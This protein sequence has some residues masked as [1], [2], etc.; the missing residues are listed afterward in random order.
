M[1]EIYIFSQHDELLTAL[2]EETGLISAVFREELNQLP[3]QPFTFTMDAESEKAAHVLEENQVV[4]RDK[5]GELRLY[6]IKEI[7]DADGL[8]GPETIAICEPA[9]MELSEKTVVE[10][11]FIETNAQRALTAALEGTRWTG[12]VETDLSVATT[13]FFYLSA[14]D[15]IWR[16]LEVWGGEFKDVVEFNGNRITAREIRILARRGID[17]G[18]RFDIEH[19]V[20]EIQR[21]VMSYP[22]TAIYGRGASLPIEDDEGDHTGGY[23]S[24][25]DFADVEWRKSAGDPVDKPKG[26]R[27]V[28]D[29]QALQKYGRRHGDKLLHR[30]GIWQN[31]NYDEPEEVLKATWEQLLKV[32]K[33]EI[34]Y[35][36]SVHLLESLAGY[37]HEKVSLGDTARAIDR[38]FAR[39][40]EIQARVIAI[41]Y[42]LLDIDTTAVVEIGQ[43]LSAH[44]YDD[45]LDNVVRE[46]NDNRG[47]WEQ[48]AKP[49]DRNSYPDIVPEVPAGIEATGGFQII[50]VFWD[51]NFMEY[52]IQHYELFASQVKG[53]LPSPETMVYRGP[54]NGYNLKGETNTTY[55]FRARA[56]NYHDRAS[57]YTAE[58]SASTVRVMTDDL[59]FG[60]ELAERLREL[61]KEADIIGKDG[62]NFDQI[63]QDA[64]DRIHNRAKVYSDQE[65]AHAYNELSEELKS[66][67]DDVDANRKEL[68]EKEKQLKEDIG[69][70]GEGLTDIEE[71]FTEQFEMIDGR[72]NGL[73]SKGEVENLL[74]DKVDQT[75]YDKRM[76]EIGASVEG[77]EF[78]LKQTSGT[79]D[80]L[81]GDVVNLREITADLKFTADGFSTS[82]QEIEKSLDEKVDSEVYRERQASLD[83]TLEGITGSVSDI[84]SDLTSITDRQAEFS[85]TL[86]GFSTSVT[87]LVT[88][89]RGSGSG[90][91]MLDTSSGEKEQ[92]R[93][94]NIH[95][96]NRISANERE[97]WVE[98]T[99]SDASTT[100]RYA[101]MGATATN[102]LQGLELNQYYTFS[103][104][105][106]IPSAFTGTLPAFRSFSYR[107][108]GWGS[109]NFPIPND[110][111]RDKWV[112][113]SFTFKLHQNATGSMLRIEMRG[114]ANQTF[115]ARKF[116][117]EKGTVAS[118]WSP[119]SVDYV[120]RQTSLDATLEGISGRV[121]TTEDNLGSITSR[122]GTLELTDST[123][124]TRITEISNDL[125]GKISREGYSTSS[126]SSNFGGQWTRFARVELRAQYHQKYATFEFNGGNHSG[127]VG[128]YG[129]LFL[130]VKQQMAIGSGNP[131]VEMALRDSKRNIG[132]NDFKAVL[133]QNASGR[134]IVDFYLRIRDNHNGFAISSYNEGGS[135]SPSML[136]VFSNQGF[137]TSVPSGV[138]WDASIDNTSL[139]RISKAE[140]AIEQT[141]EA[142]T[143]LA[144]QKEVDNLSGR[145]STSEGRIDVMSNQIGLRVEKDGIISAINIT[146]EQVKIDTRLLQI[147]NFSNLIRDSEME[148]IKLHFIHAGNWSMADA[149]STAMNNGRVL[150]LGTTQNEESR[151]YLGGQKMLRVKE[152]EQY[153]FSIYARPSNSSPWNSIRLRFRY[154]NRAGAHVGWSHSETHKPPGFV[155]TK[156]VHNATV[157]KDAYYLEATLTVL[158]EGSSF[159]HHFQDPSLVRRADTEMIVDGSITAN[160]MTANSITAGNAAIANAA[161]TRANLQQAIISNAYIADG[162][163]QNAKIANG[164]I[165]NAKI[166]NATITDGKIVSLTANKITA[167][168]IDAS[169]VNIIASG[170]GVIRMNRE[171]F[172]AFDS[173][174]RR[175]ILINVQNVGGI[176]SDP[177]V[178]RFFDPSGSNMGYIGANNNDTFSIYSTGHTFIDSTRPIEFRSNEFRFNP[179]RNQSSGRYWVMGWANASGKSGPG[180]SLRPDTS[181]WGSIGT[182]THRIWESWINHLHT[183]EQHQISTREVKANIEE[184]NVEHFA[185][186]ID[187]VRLYSYNYK[188]DDG[189]LFNHKTYGVIAEELP[190]EFLGQGSQLSL[191][192]G[193]FNTGILAKV[194]MQDMVLKVVQTEVDELK[195]NV[196]LLEIENQLL[197]REIEKLKER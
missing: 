47:K 33:P 170:T 50:Q 149:G 8:D 177:A 131:L 15:S 175:R 60:E 164:A 70:I 41:E 6:V 176:G 124:Q 94:N 146:P 34:N 79:V 43:F 40:I 197:K 125:K 77:I 44:D 148:D 115:R 56:I 109:E 99:S 100:D 179:M 147:G 193:N 101:Q 38:N 45:R 122:V 12:T 154:T 55:Y 14:I 192:T 28:G 155:Y 161:I 189:T 108:G 68:V 57:N 130:R 186:L 104:E 159:N 74:G 96:R 157:P 190:Q 42:D 112:T 86:D 127:A 128:D 22:V 75:V 7:D 145:M 98:Y 136:E 84:T 137:S 2:S 25:I 52:Y 13:N 103:M 5:E 123:F 21:T 59:L 140:T 16:I 166:A 90:K 46:I 51:F 167:G 185:N 195:D 53:F 37:E 48:P 194:K 118:S 85:N 35:K 65:I 133:I 9:F 158:N 191:N 160:H 62:I 58:V 135:N 183:F 152:G 93:L 61:N 71:H 31:G 63:Q 138:S 121:T 116:Q 196:G 105:I 181:G 134:V 113:V 67:H 180:P 82:I 91:N 188:N 142:I 169:S 184:L 4:F 182:G 107:N 156:L 151:I 117:L 20:A 18:K 76:L 144:T 81:T 72:F 120:K 10:R 139:G 106:Y 78:D 97:Q 1:A 102:D 119:S 26:Q 111:E 24:Y 3:S 11:R 141:S 89:V 126:T 49:F 171:G 150:T 174:N 187:G 66:V 23:T 114:N 30:E 153:S 29:P 143:L 88:G 163:I 73:I 64:L 95:T 162:A 39:P 165:D 19:N 69:R 168:T 173:N 17:N 83:L 92:P 36:L 80:N 178:V 132:V 54:L 110:I 32:N 27:W 129:L 172:S 87:E